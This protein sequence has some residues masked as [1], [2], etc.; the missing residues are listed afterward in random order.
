MIGLKIFLLLPCI[1]HLIHDIYLFP[2]IQLIL[3]L[4]NMNDVITDSL[5]GTMYNTNNLLHL[6]WLDGILIKNFLAFLK[7][8]SDQ[9]ADCGD[10]L[11]LCD[12]TAC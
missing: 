7:L 4:N 10:F 6:K 12:H 8:S 2:L 5:D 11:L 1:F 9:F 3:H